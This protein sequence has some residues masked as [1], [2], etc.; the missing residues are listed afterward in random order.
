[1]VNIFYVRLFSYHVKRIKEIKQIFITIN[2]YHITNIIKSDHWSA[3]KVDTKRHVFISWWTQLSLVSP[4]S[5]KTKAIIPY[6]NKIVHPKCHLCQEV[7]KI[8][9][10]IAKLLEEH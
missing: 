3:I 4:I 6:F 1:M 5:I 9:Y 8:K 7:K 2:L 10:I